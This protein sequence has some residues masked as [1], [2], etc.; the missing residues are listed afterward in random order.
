MKTK[1]LKLIALMFL[2]IFASCQEKTKKAEEPKNEEPIAEA[3]KVPVYDTNDP[4]SMLAA[5]EYAHGGWGDLWNKKDVQYTYDYR[6]PDGKADVSTERYVFESEAS[7][8]KYSQHDINVMPG[9]KG[10]VSQFFNGDSTIVMV[11]GKKTDDEQLNGV[12]GFLR[13]ANYFWFV[14]PYKLNDK[15]TISSYEGQ[16]ELNG[17][18]YDKLKVTYD[19]EIT[20]KEQNDIYVLYVNPET[21]HIDRFYFSLPF[22]GV[23]DPVIIADYT[24]EDIEGQMIATKRKYYMPSEAGYSEEPSI[25]QTLTDISFN[26]SYTME[27]IKL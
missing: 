10:D 5:I 18:T 23:N 21:K 14:M 6:Y 3:P 15:G 1:N 4:K 22:L 9:K 7:Y 8:A 13:R 26:N 17:T 2:V 11:D 12:G 25:V 19:S 16:E 27:T 20:G 24:Y